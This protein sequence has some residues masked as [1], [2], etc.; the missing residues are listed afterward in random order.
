MSGNL[1]II[2][3]DSLTGD[4]HGAA[5]L[6]ITLILL[7][8]LSLIVLYSARVS[9][10][11]QK[12][13]ANEYRARQA[14]EA[15]QA[16][17]EI[18]AASLNNWDIRKQILV[19]NDNNGIIDLQQH[20]TIGILTNDA[21]YTVTYNNTE[22]PNNFRLIELNSTGW[23]DDKTASAKINQI[24]QVVPLLSKPPDAGVTG[25]MDLTMDGNIELINTQSDL[26]A[27]AGGTI[28]MDSSVKAITSNPGK[29]GITA[30]DTELKGLQN[31]DEFFE[32]YFAMT[33]TEAENQSTYLR[34]DANT[35]IDRDDQVTNPDLYPGQNT[36]ISGN[37]TIKSS[38][39]SVEQ[40]VV[41]IIDGNLVL[42]GDIE[43]W[44]L[45]YI[46]EHGDL[47]QTSG[48]IQLHG[49]LIVESA[50][51][52][53]NGELIVEYNLDHL[54]PPAGGNGWYAKVAGTWRDF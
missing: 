42:D 30:N 21:S 18:A 39:G 13:S 11:E 5:T 9:L 6:A 15:A 27:R 33:K 49:A 2:R 43:I 54:V 45:I 46:T 8:S 53:T 14:F 50:T 40:P 44:G 1:A 20:L 48:N 32:H 34:C 41:L 7:F 12:I 28:T 35:C 29:A 38:I 16:G 23:S 22:W 37:T 26:N 52:K 17:L 47:L 19:D 24:L 25:Y 4:E 51:L 31:N 3:N 36:W 10:I